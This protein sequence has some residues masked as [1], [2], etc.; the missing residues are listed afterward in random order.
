MITR[1][2]WLQAS[3]VFAGALALGPRSAFAQR[4]GQ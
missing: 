4:P 2:Q 3:C 1:R